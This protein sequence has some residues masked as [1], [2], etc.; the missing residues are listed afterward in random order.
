[1]KS[2]TL[3]SNDPEEGFLRGEYEDWNDPEYIPTTEISKE[4]HL[5]DYKREGK[6]LLATSWPIVITYLLEVSLEMVT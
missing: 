1:M 3:E 6:A 2:E 4:F 5:K